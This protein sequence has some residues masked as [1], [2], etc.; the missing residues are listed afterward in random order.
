MADGALAVYGRLVAAQVRSQA[1]YR[2]S[3]LVE[4]VGSVLFA[5]IDVG[6]VLIL[7]N[8]TRTLGGFAFR[9][10]FLMASLAGCA[11]SLADIC[12]GNIERI[13]FYVRTGLLDAI[14][15]RPLGALPQLLAVDAAPR[16]VGRVLFTTGLVAVATGTARV[17]WT[18]A[19]VVLLL[20][21]PVSGAVLF[22]AVFVATATVA[23]WWIESGEFANA[24]TYGGRDFT[25]YP[26]TVYNGAFRRVFA[27]GLGFAFV[28]YYPALALL[29]RRDPLGL[30]AVAGWAGPPVALAAAGAAAILW[31]VA[32]RHY[33]SV[34]S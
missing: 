29:G 13:R 32:I 23:F 24:L 27:Y 2:T 34:G 6:S 26:M 31:K 16:R 5:L 12:V 21:T 15:V 3:F 9:E 22:G 1:Q 20:V 14:L 7:F 19:K 18:P 17:H 8:V 30:P 25:S 28:G 33:R 11:F 4:I 10:A